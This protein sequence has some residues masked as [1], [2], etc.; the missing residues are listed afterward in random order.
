MNLEK[1][2]NLDV[3]TTLE[4]DVEETNSSENFF[5][6]LESAVNGQVADAPEQTNQPETERVTQAT[7]PVAT[8]NERVDW[9]AEA[10]TLKKRYSDSSK[11][12]QRLKSELDDVSKYAKYA[13]LIDHLNN[14]PS[15]VEALKNH[16][17]GEI[18]PQFAEDFVFDAHEAVTNPDSES[19]KAL[20]Q[21]IDRESDKKVSMRLQQVR[22]ENDT[23]IRK[24]RLLD[25]VEE[26]KK[27][28][29][30][31]EEEFVELQNWAEN[32]ELSLNDIYL[33]KNR[34]N[35][36]SNVASQ[37][38]QDMLRQMKSVQNIPSSASN[39]NSAPVEKDYNDAVF[40]VLRGLDDGAENLF[41]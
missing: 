8:G 35:V 13:P 41:G 10:D 37:T 40:D 26:F 23:N 18:K 32:N 7:G 6:D 39:I 34:E 29:H 21:M 3:E 24:A 17:S 22:Q 36:A 30:M 20:K 16:I 25:E 14:D 1:Y 38:K 33:L 12:A 5:N 28:K 9:K 11:E 31:S 4:G 15:S 19:G 27:E 2:G